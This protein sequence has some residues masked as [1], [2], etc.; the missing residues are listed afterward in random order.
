MKVQMKEMLT[1][2]CSV[3]IMSFFAH[4]ISAEKTEHRLPLD[5]HHSYQYRDDLD[6]LMK[7]RYLR[8]LTT[9]NKTNFFILEGHFFGYEYELLKGYEASLNKK[10]KKKELGVVFEFI[11]VARDQLIS[12]L[13]NGYGDIAAAGL[14]ITAER[15]KKVAFTAPYLNGIDELLVTH[16]DA[17]PILEPGDIAGKEIL[18]RASSSY[19]DS[20]KSLN[21]KL[22]D[23]GKAPVKIKK[24][25]E[26]LETEDILELVNSGAVA[27]T[28]CDSHLAKIWSGTLKNL[29]VHEDVKL[30]SGGHLAWMV[31]K[32]NLKLKASLDTY[33]KSRKKGTKLGN[34][35]FNRYFKKNPWI[36][37]P[38]KSEESDKIRKYKG[39][40]QKYAAKYEFDWILVLALAYQE[41]GLDQNK[42]NPSGA[43]GIMQILPSTAKSK[44]IGIKNI[45]S[46][47]NNIH[48]GVKYLSYLRDNYFNDEAIRPRDRIRL[49]I[50]A[51]NAGPAK[52]RKARATAQKM[53]LNPNEWFRNVELAVL[54]TVGQETVRYVSNINKY[55]IVYRMDLREKVADKSLKSSK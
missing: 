23:S 44:P 11:P 3:F 12:K 39:L 1:I 37:N 34:I 51:Y 20:L 21:D 36:K 28:L 47:E 48:A 14:T 13:I 45:S 15:S 42:K 27:M 38:L 35:Y 52:I 16:K 6:G 8:V 5:V 22:A 50:A 33:L 9:L 17:A 2:F 40:F 25:D 30:R 29:K 24:A 4:V 53:G 41:S 46:A 54:K 10:I 55:Y 18:V 31:R 32:E 7:R 43:T 26:T 19:F 49:A